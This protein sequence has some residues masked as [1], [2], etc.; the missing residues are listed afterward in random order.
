MGRRGP[1]IWKMESIQ[2]GIF[3]SFV[4]SFK[5]NILLKLRQVEFSSPK[6]LWL[7]VNVYIIIYFFSRFIMFSSSLGMGK[8]R[9]FLYMLEKL[10]FTSYVSK[11]L[12]QGGLCLG[13]KV[14]SL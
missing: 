6:P 8:T 11:Q 13:R 10:P 12:G 5:D 7:V 1:H 9:V 14:A 2:N 4:S 3:F